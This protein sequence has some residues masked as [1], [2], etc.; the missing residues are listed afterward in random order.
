MMNQSMTKSCDF[1]PGNIF[2]FIC[3]CLRK[4]VCMLPDIKERRSDSPLNKL[5]IQNLF[6]RNISIIYL[7]FQIM[8]ILNN[9]F[10][11]F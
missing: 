3:K 5:I 11:S 9:L 8:I 7:P 10:K 4:I 6:P 1:I 2:I